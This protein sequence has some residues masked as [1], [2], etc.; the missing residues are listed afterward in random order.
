MKN[1]MSHAQTQYL[2]CKHEDLQANTS[3]QSLP[4]I[5]YPFFYISTGPL[6]SNKLYKLRTK[7]QSVYADFSKFSLSTVTKYL[8]F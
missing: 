7:W 6:V 4:L 1:I 2:I 3:E 5:Y 8:Y